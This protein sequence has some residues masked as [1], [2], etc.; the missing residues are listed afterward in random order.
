MKRFYLVLVFSLFMFASSL[1]TA[2]AVVINRNA[3]ITQN[4]TTIELNGGCII[5]SFTSTPSVIE[6][7][8]SAVL[9][10]ST[11]NCSNVRLS[12]G[13]FVNALQFGTS[14]STGARQ[15]TT[16]YT[17]YGTGVNGIVA[18]AVTTVT[19]STS[20]TSA[21]TITS[22]Y[23]TPS[24]VAYGQSATIYYSTSNCSNPTLS[25]GV[26]ALPST[27]GSISTGPIYQNT[28]FTLSAYGTNG[29]NDTERITIGLSNNSSGSSYCSIISFYGSP[30]SVSN[31]QS[32]TLYWKTAG[33]SSIQINGGS[34][35]NYS[36]LPSEGS[37][38]TGAIYA[39][40]PFTLYAYGSNSVSASTSISVIGGAYPVNY[41]CNDRVD[42]D[43]D[44]LTDWPN[45]TGCYSQY[46][47]DESNSGSGYGSTL[48]TLPAS[49]VGSTTARLNGAVTLA[50]GTTNAYFEYGTTVTLGKTTG[51]QYI[52]GSG[53]V[54]FYDTIQTTAS[55]NYYYRAV[56]QAN[57]VLIRGSIMSFS[58][59]TGGSTPIY[60]SS[61]PSYSSKN[62]TKTVAPTAD[63]LLTVTNTKEKLF[64]GETVDYTVTYENKSGKRLNKALLTFVLPQGL[65]L[66]QTTQG[67]MISPSTMD[68]SIGELASGEKG[69]IFLQALV[70]QTVATDETLVT[71]GTLEYTYPNGETD[72]VVGFV[73]NTAG[74]A[75]GFGGMAFGSGFFP[76]TIF[77]WI[78]TII[79]I[80]VVILIIRRIVKSRAAQNA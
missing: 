42:N 76:T 80:L 35:S 38:P 12:G 41:A 29:T 40:T 72:S 52:P 34:L 70:G 56:M 53:T 24:S 31:G 20:V 65:T 18:S 30:Q 57:G 4:E 54:S 27:S 22:F 43:G 2:Q 44:G 28:S 16:Q 1:G 13:G 68:I 55:T 60:F 62:S 3:P 58:T 59:K 32:S 6:P 64:P 15:G 14:V 78:L 47:N 50:S 46:D 45:D 79:V 33:C 17:L 67:T 9:T 36:Y 25:P 51:L 74:S 63:V 5:N 10:W 71:N 39:T 37:L 49:N 23:S 75:S 48:I 8:G 73:L 7:G 61:A 66:I 21:C 19:V 69:T 77:G 26:G 11:K